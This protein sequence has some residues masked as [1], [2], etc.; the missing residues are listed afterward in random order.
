[1]RLG[2]IALLLAAATPAQDAIHYKFDGRCGTAVVNYADPSPAPRHGLITASATHQPWVQG[3]WGGA[4]D[5]NTDIFTVARIDTGWSLAAAAGSFSYAAWVRIPGTTGIGLPHTLLTTVG[6]GFV[7]GTATGLFEGHLLTQWATASG[8]QGLSITAAD[9]KALATQRWVHLA[10]VI[11]VAAGSYTAYVDGAVDHSNALAG[12]APGNWSGTLQVGALGSSFVVDELVV[13][14]RAFSA[15]EVTALHAGPRAAAGAYGAGGCRGA[16]LA[17]TGGPPRVPNPGFRLQVA[18]S[19]GQAGIYSISVASN[20]CAFGPIPIPFDLGLI[21]PLVAGCIADAPNDMGTIGGSYAG[22]V[23]SVPLP[24]PGAAIFIGFGVYCQAAL[25]EIPSGVILTVEHW[26][27]PG[28]SAAGSRSASAKGRRCGSRCAESLTGPAG[29][30][31]H[32]A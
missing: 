12:S 30:R 1:M 16:L 11:D 6:T 18:D 24:I 21:S 28:D 2:S 4:F 13:A 14:T 22:G 26:L 17:T 19:N 23:A 31:P 7:S 27:A 32:A 3:L 10:F 15:A 20:R 8:P 25:I 5:G 9:V 29:S